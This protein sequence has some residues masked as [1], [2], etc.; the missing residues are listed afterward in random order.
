MDAMVAIVVADPEIKSVVHLAGKTI[1]ID[2][3]YS[4]PSINRVR[5]A[6][7]TAGAIDV[8]LSKSQATAISRLV[9]KEVQAAIVGLVTISSADSFPELP[10]LQTFR[11]RLSPRSTSKEP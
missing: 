11:I 6:L 7:A 8:Q 5:T 3:K 1:A 2:D 4:E 9:G 10:H